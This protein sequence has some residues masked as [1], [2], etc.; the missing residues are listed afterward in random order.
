MRIT[1][2]QYTF[3]IAFPT[4][5]L[6]P[7]TKTVAWGGAFGFGVCDAISSLEEV[8]P[9]NNSSLNINLKFTHSNLVSF[10]TADNNKKEDANRQI[11]KEKR[12]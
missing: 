10:Y 4:R 3:S 6:P 7:V 2:A 5:P 12:L 9:V 8:L 1:Y 11:Q